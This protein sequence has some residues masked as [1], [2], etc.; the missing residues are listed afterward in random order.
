MK[1]RCKSGD[2]AIIVREELGCEKNIGKIVA[3]RGPIR[4]SKTKGPQWLIQS[5]NPRVTWYFKYVPEDG[6]AR[7]R[8]GL[9]FEH[10]I[11]HP[12]A[13]LVPIIG[14]DGSSRHRS[15]QSQDVRD[16]RSHVN[17]PGADRLAQSPAETGA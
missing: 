16:A 3:V 5:V 13:W 15:S 4:M 10:A 12:D 9:K 6:L 2:L 1:T 7:S 14:R 17:A 8:R 11:D